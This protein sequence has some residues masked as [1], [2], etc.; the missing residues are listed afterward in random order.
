MYA[1]GYFKPS[2]LQMWESKSGFCQLV[3]WAGVMISDVQNWW[4]LDTHR[5]RLFLGMEI[6]A[7]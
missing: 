2:E 7:C 3:F 6:M 4:R 1:E 5:R